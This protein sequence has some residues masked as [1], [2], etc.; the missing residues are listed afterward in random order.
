MSQ[1]HE[2]QVP[3]PEPGRNSLR[4]LGTSEGGF[5]LIE[6]LVVILI[7]GILAAV[8]IPTLLSQRGKAY[9]ASARELAA[10]AETAAETIGTDNGGDFHRVS[11]TEL[12]VYEPALKVSSGNEEPYVSEAHGLP[13]GCSE[14]GCTGYRIS[15]TA[16]RTHDV[17]SIERNSTGEVVRSCVQGTAND[18]GCTG[19]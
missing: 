10:T 11:P 5:T 7:I 12:S 16:A 4:R 14:N 6:L 17:F 13:S 2:N 3:T 18:K 8:A 9:D 1:S 19:W 15:V